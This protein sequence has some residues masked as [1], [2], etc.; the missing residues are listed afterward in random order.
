VADVIS[1]PKLNNKSIN[2]SI[3]LLPNPNHIIPHFARLDKLRRIT[4]WKHKKT[5]RLP[6]IESPDLRHPDHP[7]QAEITTYLNNRGM[8]SCTVEC[9]VSKDQHCSVTQIT[10]FK[11][12]PCRTRTPPRESLCMTKQRNRLSAFR[13]TPLFIPLVKY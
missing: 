1:T 7:Q 6:A 9:D 8:P 10:V 13:T 2:K 12:R 4:S 5:T 3:N 11:S